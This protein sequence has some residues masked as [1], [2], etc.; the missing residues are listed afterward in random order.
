MFN[1]IH[2]ER[3]IFRIKTL[4]AEQILESRI[5]INEFLTAIV[6]F[7]EVNLNTKNVINYVLMKDKYAHCD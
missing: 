2:N 6:R 4:T 7:D 5:V 3:V 1:K